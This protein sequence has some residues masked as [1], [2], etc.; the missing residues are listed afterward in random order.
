MTSNSD[1][2]QKVGELFRL[3]GIQRVICVDD[4]YDITVE[5]VLDL[6]IGISDHPEKFVSI[7]SFSGIDFSGYPDEWSPTLKRR[8]N[9]LTPDE[10]AKLHHYLIEVGDFTHITPPNQVAQLFDDSVYIG[11]SPVNWEK[12]R[13]KLFADSVNGSTLF[14]FDQN[15]GK[16]FEDR[17]MQII[18]EIIR[19]ESSDNIICGLL[20]STFSPDEEYTKWTDYS[21]EYN[22]NRDRFLLISK[23]HASLDSAAGMI[24]L[25]VLNR[26]CA[27]LK[28][29]V[30]D[31]LQKA[32]EFAHS[33]IDEIDIY[34]FEHMVFS[35]S[36][37]EGIWEPDTLLRLY[38]IFQRGEL[39]SLARNTPSVRDTADK[40]R[41]T[42]D[43]GISNKST[44]TKFA[45]KV[46]HYEQFENPDYLVGH[47][48]PLD[49][50]DIFATTR[51]DDP[52][53]YILLAQP[54]E[55]MVR[56]GRR[57]GT[58]EGLFARIMVKT[59]DFSLPSTAYYPLKYFSF[60]NDNEYVVDFRRALTI[61][62]MVLDLCIFNSDGISKLTLNTPL[63]NGLIPAWVKYHSTVARYFGKYLEKLKRYAKFLDEETKLMLLPASTP[64]CKFK[65]EVS[66]DFS[67]I[68]YGLKRVG[69][70]RQPTS[71]E[72]LLKLSHFNSR[73]AFDHELD[74]S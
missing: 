2:R 59:S 1:I 49:L 5:A 44:Q 31:V 10:L 56:N 41:Q 26:F 64:E 45:R 51:G 21:T 52:K 47:H 4:Y 53:L 70:L 30:K 74:R 11:L 50:G 28:R 54:C 46:M 16:G 67:S 8:L 69:R 18:Q 15:L 43:I 40:L 65:P 29:G 55:L 58:N 36:R 60:D 6:C 68:D 33:K 62:L 37:S 25:I 3:T 12:E 22:V 9:D 35:T 39:L 71:G 27:L 38:S 48:I 17:G 34:D 32:S 19:T 61:N 73:A 24:K 42:I 20:S 7:E 23:Q 72:V 63:S 66:D 57:G 13:S 14:L